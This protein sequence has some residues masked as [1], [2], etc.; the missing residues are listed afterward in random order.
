MLIL[1]SHGCILRKLGLSSL[2][3]PG[4]PNTVCPVHAKSTLKSQVWSP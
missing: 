1:N 3:A 2:I 4:A